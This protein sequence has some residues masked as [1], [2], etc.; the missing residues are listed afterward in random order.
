MKRIL[1]LII[2]AS[3]CFAAMAQQKP[4]YQSFVFEF[5]EGEDMFL[6]PYEGNDMKLPEFTELINANRAQLDKE[7]MYVLIESYA[8]IGNQSQSAS[9]VAHIQRNR[10]KGELMLR[11]GITE[12]MFATEKY[13]PNAYGNDEL[14]N[15]VV[16]TIPTPTIKVLELLGL[17]RAKRVAQYNIDMGY[18]ELS[19]EELRSEID[20]ANDKLDLLELLSGEKSKRRSNFDENRKEKLVSIRTNFVRLATLT[21]DLGAE[22]RFNPQW[23]VVLHGNYTKWEWDYQHRRYAMWQVSP[24]LRYHFGATKSW[25]AGF[26]YQTGEFDYKLGDNGYQSTK[27][28]HTAGLVAGYNLK[29]G[30]RLALDLGIGAGYTYAPYDKYT[31]I[32]DLR[33]R[34]GVGTKNYFGLNQA[35]VTLSWR[36]F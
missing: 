10:V 21:A 36:L 32:N 3:L 25:Y 16:V 14:R 13:N 33:V 29:L 19:P 27:F 2:T 11:T 17:S 18:E 22:Y 34:S 20:K 4:N 31:I 30:R 23:S 15:V 1:L 26:A 35:S 8:T 7:Q 12:L 9:E 6:V 24:E 5:V 28:Y